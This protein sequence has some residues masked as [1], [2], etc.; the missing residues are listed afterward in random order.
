VTDF[1]IAAALKGQ[2]WERAKGELRSLVALQGS[3][4]PQWQGC[5]TRTPYSA[6][7]WEK[8]NDL[9]ARVELFISQVEGE[10]LHE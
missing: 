4:N 9:H 3:H 8:F 5:N 6:A 1:N 2:Q 10:G 7:Q